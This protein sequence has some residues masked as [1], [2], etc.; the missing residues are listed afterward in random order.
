[1][2]TGRIT[3]YVLLHITL[4]SFG[5]TTNRFHVI[6][7]NGYLNR[8]EARGRKYRST[9]CTS[10]RTMLRASFKWLLDKKYRQIETVSVVS[11]ERGQAKC[12]FFIRQ[13]RFRIRP[14][15][16][17]IL[18]RFLLIQIPNIFQPMA[19]KITLKR[20]TIWSNEIRTSVGTVCA[21]IWHQS[22]NLKR[23]V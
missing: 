10:W 23:N 13:F 22:G 14:I 18:S 8:Y 16:L 2:G 3:T 4:F 17:I 1:M 7:I 6:I 12:K 11:A 19:F 20:M 5:A 15:L 9:R 21:F